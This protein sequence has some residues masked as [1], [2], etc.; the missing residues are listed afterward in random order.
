VHDLPFQPLAECTVDSTSQSS[1]ITGTP[2]SVVDAGGSRVSSA[3]RSARVRPEP[4]EPT[5]AEEAT[6]E[7][8]RAVTSRSRSASLSAASG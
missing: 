2:T 8:T 6:D 4:S 5:V 1:S 3:T 7:A